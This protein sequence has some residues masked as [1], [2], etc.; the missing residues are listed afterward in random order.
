[1]RVKFIF[2]ALQLKFQSN[3]VFH[4][5]ICGIFINV[6]VFDFLTRHF[7]YLCEMPLYVCSQ[8]PFPCITLTSHFYKKHHSEVGHETVFFQH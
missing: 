2:Y 3:L 4:V 5:C 7:E 1:M 8:T 6:F